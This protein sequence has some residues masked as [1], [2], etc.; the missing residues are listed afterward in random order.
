M[1]LLDV[2][3]DYFFHIFKLGNLKVIVFMMSKQHK[4]MWEKKSGIVSVFQP[5]CLSDGKKDVA[6]ESSV[7]I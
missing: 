6:R 4:R 1:D 5:I 2:D 7:D 3:A